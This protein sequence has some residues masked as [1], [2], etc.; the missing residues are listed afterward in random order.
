MT[1]SSNIVAAHLTERDFRL[2]TLSIPEMRGFQDYED[3]LDYRMAT[4]WG[5]EMAGYTVEMVPV[6]LSKFIAWRRSASE[7]PT[8][9]ALDRFARISKLRVVETKPGKEE[10]QG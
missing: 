10:S 7:A 9:S 3:W 5:L 8:I 2:A 4:S 6:D 1:E